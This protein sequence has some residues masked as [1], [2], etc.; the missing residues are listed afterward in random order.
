MSIPSQQFQSEPEVIPPTQPII[1]QKTVKPVATYVIMG[2]TI[3]FYL[4]QFLVQTLTGYDYLF[5]LG[6]KVNQY[7]L[8]GE[9][10]RLITPILLHGSIIHIGFNMYAL[11]SLGRQLEPHFGHQRFALLYLA[12][13]FAGNVLSFLIT[14][15]PSLGASTAIFGLLAAEGVFIY[16]NR[17]MYG[18]NAKKM[19]T[20]TVTIAVI[21]LIFGFSI[22]NIDNFG[23]LGGLLGGLIFSWIGGPVWKVEGSFP[24]FDVVDSRGGKHIW[25]G[26]LATVA[27][28]GVLAGVK[29]VLR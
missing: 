2:V 22:S 24:V 15:N 29:F 5:L 18:E 28:F 8:Q 17:K 14:P 1:R 16:Q 20:N 19:L 12:S 7:I 27:V 9:L 23:H 26:M 11:Y 10:W 4:I 6:G 13:G 21:N 25:L 3:F